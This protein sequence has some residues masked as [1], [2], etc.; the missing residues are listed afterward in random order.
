MVQAT[1]QELQ[2]E[3]QD[4]IGQSKLDIG[5]ILKVTNQLSK[6]DDKY[7]RFAID[8]KT[9]IH[10]GRDSIKDHTT[11]L[12]ELVKNSYDADAKNVEVEVFC[13]DGND[14]IRVSDNGFGMTKENLLENWLRIGFSQKRKSKTSQLG[15]R[16]TGEKGIGRIST[17]RLGGILELVTKTMEDGIIGLTVNWD[18]FDVEGK[19]IFDI[20][21]E[22]SKPD[23]ISIP[24]LNGQESLT[25]TEIKISRLRQPWSLSNIENL[26]YELS[27]LT[28]P[29]SSVTDFSIELKNDVAEVFS[30]KVSP[31]F[32][33]AA[34]IELTAVFDNSKSEVLYTIKDKYTD[35]AETHT[36]KWQQ[37]LAKI[38][39]EK[40]GLP[41]DADNGSATTTNASQ[42][43]PQ[44]TLGP[45]TIQLMF[46]L[47]EA[48]SIANTGLRLADLRSFLD[49]NAGIK[50]YRDNIAVKPY[51]FP[52][53]QFGYDWLEL[54]DRKSRNPAGI[55]RGDEYMVN[56]NQLIGA[57][58]ITRDDN[59]K[60]VD[61]AARE[62]LVESEEFNDLKLLVEG[63]I[64]M[65]ESHRAKRL[66]EIQKTRKQKKAT[67]TLQEAERI[68]SQLKDVV[69]GLNQIR[70]AI[71]IKG[72]DASFE[73]Q[74]LLMPLE[75][76]I[77]EV[78][79][80]KDEVS[81]TIHDLLHWQRVLSGLA[82]MGI[83]NAVFGHETENS[84]G[85]FKGSVNTAQLLLQDSPPDV[86]GALDELEKAIKHSTKI[87]AWGAYAL[88]RIQREKRSKRK[89]SIL[90]I[91]DGVVDELR[92][93]FIASAIHIEVVG[94][95]IVESTYPMDIESILINLLTNAYTA[96]LLNSGPRKVVVTLGRE[97]LNERDGFFF[98]VADSGPGIAPEFE[99]RL[100]EPLFSTKN[101]QNSKSKSVGTG[102]GLTI[103]KSI[104][105]ELSGEVTYGKSDTLNGAFFKIWLPKVK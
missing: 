94:D 11:A 27:S 34:E 12:I 51:G 31:E 96:A 83:S 3:L 55:G 69:G 46:F 10:L 80:I 92:S 66:P 49:N 52:S 26:Y 78:E 17:D 67:S 5:A 101:N 2:S 15:R 76:S 48:A 37:L 47:R 54:G 41:D 84:V 70:T 72:K 64:L 45:V 18:E 71:E 63:S 89:T 25:G 13:L 7:Q 62:G 19:D 68:T 23:S 60:L 53:A 65:L 4:L 20:Q 90:K 6:L 97:K 50:I 82:T 39:R 87:E 24:K 14:L 103:V 21:I 35:G 88:T 28:P 59:P 33:K 58:F 100:F 9:L 86:E 75:R 91:I 56:P 44:L 105:E 32:Y 43:G 79:N 102:L 38:N 77:S 1:A 8:A 93:A 61:S 73:T 99:H 95:N 30:K 36:I 85:Q 40:D 22:L 81:V 29:F 74:H 57:I 16:K 42:L 104:S 98:S